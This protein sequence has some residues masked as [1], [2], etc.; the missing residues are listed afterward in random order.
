MDKITLIVVISLLSLISYLTIW[1]FYP[2][3]LV[4]KIVLSLTVLAGIV[5]MI[6]INKYNLLLK[7][8]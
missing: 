5:N 8:Q 4:L 1:V 3:P 7:E 6:L 2:I